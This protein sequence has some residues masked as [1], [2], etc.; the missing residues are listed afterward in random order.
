MQQTEQWLAI[1]PFMKA[2]GYKKVPKDYYKAV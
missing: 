2:V 1:A